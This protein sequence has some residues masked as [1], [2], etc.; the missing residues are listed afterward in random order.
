MKLSRRIYYIIKVSTRKKFYLFDRVVR[1]L[2]V[3]FAVFTIHRSHRTKNESDLKQLS[4][5][6]DVGS[7]LHVERSGTFTSTK[8]YLPRIDQ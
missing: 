5:E 3:Y 1:I 6:L 8:G 4:E 7:V 2:R